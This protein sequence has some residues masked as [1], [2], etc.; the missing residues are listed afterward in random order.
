MDDWAVCNAMDVVQIT[1]QCPSARVRSQPQFSFPC[2]KALA[3]DLCAPTLALALQEI[4]LGTCWDCSHPKVMAQLFYILP[5][6]MSDIERRPHRFCVFMAAWPWRRLN[7]SCHDVSR[8]RRQWFTYFTVCGVVSQ[9]F[10]TVLLETCCPF[11]L[12]ASMQQD[13]KFRWPA[14]S[15]QACN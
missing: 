8:A 7:C 1:K 4:R 13:A 10:S 5:R 6:Q 11:S 2:Y 14:R 9:E 15:I 3:I 12:L